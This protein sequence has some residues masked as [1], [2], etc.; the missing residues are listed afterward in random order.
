MSETWA[1]DPDDPQAPPQSVWDRLDESARRSVVA[2][3]PSSI[4]RVAPPEGDE[5]TEPKERSKQT[6]REYFRRTG[7]SVYLGSELAVYYPG[8]SH[9]A[10]DLIAVLDV[11][12][13]ARQKWVVSEEKRG[14]DFVLEIHV[15]GDRRKDYILD[16]ERYGRLGIPE[17]FLFDPPH[18]LLL[19]YRL[20]EATYAPVLPQ[21]GQ[22][23]SRVL[24][25][26][27]SLDDGRLRFATPGGGALL[28]PVEW[29]EKLRTM[30]DSAT[31]RAEAEA[32]RAEAEAQRA[33]RLAAKLEELGVDPDEV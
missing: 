2:S 11:P 8:E 31:N 12:D 30:V 14:L 19:G 25:L 22:W 21:G 10:P 4:R 15:R 26:D 3:L 20:E 24:G 27:L 1:I 7:R 5:H 6:L 23:R 13:H 29:V 32:Q 9:F 16:V 28:D 18:Q 33:E 17:Y